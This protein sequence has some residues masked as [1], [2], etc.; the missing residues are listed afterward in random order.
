MGLIRMSSFCFSLPLLNLDVIL[1]FRI[2]VLGGFLGNVEEFEYKCLGS[3]SHTGFA[4][5]G[6]YFP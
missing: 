6:L 4:Q 2:E 5:R 3:G 1:Q